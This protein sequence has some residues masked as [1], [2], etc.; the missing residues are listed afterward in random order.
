M[1]Y[2]LLKDN[3]VTNI[4]L[5]DKNN[6]HDFPNAAPCYDKPVSVGDTYIDGEFYHDG[7]K[8]YSVFEEY[9]IMMNI[10]EGAPYNE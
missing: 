7:E 9:I 4:I 6:A 3:I 2:A 10:I 1:N 5:L 8:V